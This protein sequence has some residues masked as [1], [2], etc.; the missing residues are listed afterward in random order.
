[1]KQITLPDPKTSQAKHI[2]T[3]RKGTLN[4]KNQVSNKSAIANQWRK[5]GLNG[6]EGA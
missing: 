5:V 1:M 2:N 3:N 4:L 6:V